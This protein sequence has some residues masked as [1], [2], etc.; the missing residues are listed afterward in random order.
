M[1]S[2][3]AFPDAATSTTIIGA[4]KVTGRVGSGWSVGVLEALTGRESAPW[5]DDTGFEN[6]TVV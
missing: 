1:S 3:A 6:E 5:V 2:A 4:A